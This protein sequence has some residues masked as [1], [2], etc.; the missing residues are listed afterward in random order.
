MSLLLRFPSFLFQQIVWLR[1]WLYDRG[2][3]VSQRV[4]RPVISVG[5]LTVG[6]TG[7]TPFSLW[8][9]NRIQ[10]Q[11]LKPAFVSRGYKS[12]R[13][14]PRSVT[15][16]AA[17][18]F[19]D[20][21]SLVRDEFPNIPVYV[22]ADRTEAI[23]KMLKENTAD[24]IVADD[25]FQHRR[26]KRD[27]DIVLLDAL[28]PDWHY[29]FLPAGRARESFQSL[30]RAKVVVISKANLADTKR[31]GFL[32]EKLKE[33]R[34]LKLRMN[35]KCGGFR[36]QHHRRQSLAGGIFLVS[37]VGRPESVEALLPSKPVKHNTFPDHH[38]Y[39]ATDVQRLVQEFRASGAENFVT[40]AKDAV[41]LNRFSE[42]KGVVWEMDLTVELEGDVE[43]L[44]RQIRGLV[45]SR[46]S[47]L[48]ENSV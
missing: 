34:G 40:T 36:N 4:A 46:T 33:F 44:D 19:G 15:H 8:L 16:V 30:E 2:L 37:G 12:G 47:M 22:G 32:E 38:A 18:Q 24:I 17:D 3:L 11:Q 5:N 41:K 20:E 43:E 29:R 28:E 13:S 6:G 31:L 26:L 39:S 9:L 48:V 23:A 14:H 45:Q 7:K 1:G 42:L 21:P 25:A 35:Y 27:L 10:A